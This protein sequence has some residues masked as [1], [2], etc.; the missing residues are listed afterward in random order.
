MSGQNTV[1]PGLVHCLNFKTYMAEDILTRPAYSATTPTIPGDKK[2]SGKAYDNVREFF[3]G[4]NIWDN[5]VSISGGTKNNSFYLSASRYDQEGIVPMT[6]YDK[7]TLRFNGEQK[8]GKITVGA[9]VAYSI[10]NTQKTFT[11]GGL[12]G[13]GGNGAMTAVYGWSRSD[14]MKHYLNDDGTKYRM[15]AQYQELASDRKTLLDHQQKQIIRPNQPMDRI[16][17][18]QY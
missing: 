6:G 7:T 1:T 5:T 17:Q 4:G 2:I 12:Y 15:F 9:N 13:G 3:R 16:S 18:R 8:Y 10:A 14:D 11:T